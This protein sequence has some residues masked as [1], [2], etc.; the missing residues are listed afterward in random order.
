MIREGD[1]I[2]RD[3][4]ENAQ[5][6]LNGRAAALHLQVEGFFYLMS[7]RALFYDIIICD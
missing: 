6:D 1:R 2:K 3:D 7:E 4:T 5:S